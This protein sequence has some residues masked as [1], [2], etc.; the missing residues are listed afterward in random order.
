MAKKAKQLTLSTPEG[1]TVEAA[2]A[3]RILQPE[4]V[5]SCTAIVYGESLSEQLDVGAL[6][7]ELKKLQDD[8]VQSNSLERCEA[9]LVTQAT[10]LNMIFNNSM[11]RARGQD[12]YKGVAIYMRMGLKAQAQCR[13]TVEALASLKNP[14]PKYLTQNNIAN[15]Q[16]VNNGIISDE[17][18]KLSTERGDTQVETVAEINRS[19]NGCGQEA[20]VAEQPQARPA[21]TRSNS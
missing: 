8:V 9:M 6:S 3:M 13:Q 12:T 21:H 4:I 10:L 2:A 17:Q 20:I 7:I 14:A 18:N 1:M 15:N 11:V 5:G 16:Q 19:K